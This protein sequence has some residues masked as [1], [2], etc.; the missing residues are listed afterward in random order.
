MTHRR[1]DSPCGRWLT[2]VRV[3]R[4]PAQRLRTGVGTAGWRSRRSAG[5]RGPAADLATADVVG[6]VVGLEVQTPGPRSE[7][8]PAQGRWR[9]TSPQHLRQSAVSIRLWRRMSP[10]QRSRTCHII[11][12]ALHLP[13][14]L[15]K[16]AETGSHCLSSAV[17]GLCGTGSPPSLDGRP[18]LAQDWSECN[19]LQ[20]DDRG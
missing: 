10:A 2:G 17:Y 12:Q 13:T 1:I 16:V 6:V 4:E 15:R 9:G 5:P 7:R 3:F 11:E 18:K 8:G 19:I 20:A 14:M